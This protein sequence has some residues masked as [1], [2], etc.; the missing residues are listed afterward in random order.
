[1]VILV[2]DSK[3]VVLGISSAGISGSGFTLLA[4]KG[5]FKFDAQN[6]VLDIFRFQSCR[7]TPKTGR[8]NIADQGHGAVAWSDHPQSIALRVVAAVPFVASQQVPLRMFDGM[9]R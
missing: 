3:L 4:G 6:Y 9:A 1:M 7:V 2:Q 5:A 8:L